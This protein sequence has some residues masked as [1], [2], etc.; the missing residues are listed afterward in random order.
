MDRVKAHEVASLTRPSY[1]YREAPK[2][3][4]MDVRVHGVLPAAF[5][6]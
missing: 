6:L 5:K 3:H 1:V 2:A 4:G